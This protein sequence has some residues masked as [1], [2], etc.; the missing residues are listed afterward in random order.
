MSRRRTIA[1]RGRD[2][3]ATGAALRRRKHARPD[4]PV[5][6]GRD[7][8]RDG[9]RPDRRARRPPAG[10][11]RRPR[12][13]LRAGDRDRGRPPAPRPALLPAD[14]RGHRGRDGPRPPAHLRLQ[15]GRHR[16]R[17][18]STA[19]ADQGRGG[20]RGPPGGRRHRQRGRLRQQG[21]VPPAARGGRRG[22][23]PRRDRRRRGP[24]SS[25]DRTFQPHGEDL[26]HFDHRKMVVI[27]GR[28]GYVGGSGIEDHYND[29][30]FYDVMCRVEGPIV[31]QLAV[32]LPDQLAQQRRRRARPTRRCSATSRRRRCAVAAG[33]AVPGPDDGPLERPGHRPPPDQR[34][35]R[36]GAR[37]RR[38]A[39]STSSTRTSRTGPS[40]S[41]SSR[42]RCAASGSG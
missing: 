18:S 13:D 15:A 38:R 10:P 6:P 3:A 40:S 8:G 11:P 12:P 26:L 41:G 42:P 24:A 22:R 25:A 9:R 2:R 16:R 20:R 19:L 32:G 14:A 33:R 5:R 35:H 34:H 17:R 1:H 29:E 28:V 31:A 37:G 30:R 27:D 4:R 23:R 39:R 36:A 7:P 21:P